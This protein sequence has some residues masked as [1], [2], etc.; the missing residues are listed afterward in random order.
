MDDDNTEFGLNFLRI[1]SIENILMYSDERNS[2]IS[3]SII[4][5]RMILWKERLL[6]NFLYQLDARFVTIM[7]ISFLS[8]SDNSSSDK[9]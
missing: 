1:L 9:S 6:S 2:T 7:S 8:E 5:G 4:I 3:V